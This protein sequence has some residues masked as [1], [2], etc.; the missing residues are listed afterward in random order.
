MF[1]PYPNFFLRDAKKMPPDI[2]AKFDRKALPQVFNKK[3]LIRNDGYK[4]KVKNL[5]SF[6]Y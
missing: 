1:W 6:L 3:K 4:N 2:K 5:S